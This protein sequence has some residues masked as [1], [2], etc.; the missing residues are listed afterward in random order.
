LLFASVSAHNY[1]TL[2]QFLDTVLL[3]DSITMSSGRPAKK[4]AKRA[5][6]KHPSGSSKKPP[7]A[8]AAHVDDGDADADADAMEEVEGEEEGE[9][10]EGEGKL[11]SKLVNHQLS[12]LAN[13]FIFFPL[14]CFYN[15]TT[16]LLSYTTNLL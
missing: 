12:A 3:G 15:N 6:A 11:Y 8:G 5:K 9:E 13:F 14:S 2:Q 1:T 10:A 16:N 4:P 7:T